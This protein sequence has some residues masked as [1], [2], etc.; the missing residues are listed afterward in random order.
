M[1]RLL[2][3]LLVVL[4]VRPDA[5]PGQT[6]ASA[7]SLRAGTRVRITQEGQQPRIAEVVTGRADTLFV[8]WPEFAS[9][10]AV[11]LAEVSRLEVSTGRHRKV[12]RGAVVG[13]LSAGAAGFVLGAATYSPCTSTEPFGCLLA[14][15]SRGESAAVGGAVGGVLGLI[16]G[17]L[18]GLPNREGWQRMSL[19]ARRV[20]VAV[21][22]R[23]SSTSLGVTVRF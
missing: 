13:T 14:P 6:A 11:P 15:T 7:A 12:L 1:S 2:T 20:A 5:L 4:F 18:V 3:A 16:V 23:A 19:D 17:T 9:T 22:P 10:T 21:T 8:R